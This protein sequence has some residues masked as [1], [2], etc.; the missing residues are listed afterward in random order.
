VLVALP[1][2]A[3]TAPSPAAA[4]DGGATHRA[5]APSLA[6]SPSVHVAGQAVHF[7][8]SVG[9]PGVRAL[10]LQSHLGRPGDTWTRVPRSGART[11][12]DGS[13]D[14]VFPAPSMF[15]ISYRVVGDGGLATPPYLFWAP[16]QEITLTVQGQGAETPFNTVAPGSSFTVVADTTPPVRT[17]MG[18]P[19]AI[20][21]RTVLLQ[22]RSGTQWRTIAQGVADAEGHASFSL[23]APASG[24]RVL[25]ARQERWTEG[26]NEIGWFASFPTY[27]VV[28][29]AGASSGGSG[30]RVLEWLLGRTR[31]AADGLRPTA[32]QR[33]GWGPSLF[34]F[35]WERGQDLDSPPSRGTRLKGSWVDTSDGTGRATP[36]NGA[37][38][39]QSK[40]EHLGDGDLGTTTAT[41]RGN[42][43][44]TGRWEFRMQGRVFESG[45]L[46]YRVRLELVPAGAP[47][48]TCS[49]ESVVVGAFTLGSAG[50]EVGVRSQR[51]GSV[52]RRTAAGVRLGEEPM[53]VAVEIAQDHTTWFV[54]GKPVATTK[55]RRAWLGRRLTPRLSMIGEQQEMAGTQVDSDW[56]RGWTLKRGTQ[57]RSGPG[58]A[59][60]AYSPSC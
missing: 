44:K 36:F 3:T 4:G 20:P 54:G 49:P 12:A 48:T 23:T 40:L 37:L 38:A 11:A 17:D 26:R 1:A 27:V 42:G 28:G 24:Q 33:W 19:P 29:S 18:V 43:L 52:W 13:F 8:G 30:G 57:V 56:Q 34:D 10:H 50:M 41:M 51:A 2:L 15:R 14:F 6:V 45:G 31:A 53:N 25:R 5:A 32:S 46:P 39:L 21:G 59:R 55:S 58:L 22:E 16:P 60:S 35:A 7:Q 9:Q 47:V